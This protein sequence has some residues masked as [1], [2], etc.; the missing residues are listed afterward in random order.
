MSYPNDQGNP[1][2]SIPVQSSEMPASTLVDRSGTV[3]AG[4]SAVAVAAGG[5]GYAVNDTIS[6]GNGVSL[7][8]TTV[9]AG[10]ITAVSV[11]NIGSV[12]SAA[13]PTNPVAQV[14]T[15]GAGTGATFN[16]TWGA[17]VSTQI[18]PANA[19]RRRYRIQNLSTTEVLWLN[20]TGGVAG[21]STP[22]SYGLTPSQGNYPGDYYE[23]YSVF[24]ISVYA[25]TPGHV[26]SAAEY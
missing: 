13:T 12:A 21:A 1:A 19:A 4:V 15:S 24:A 8:V 5:T 2:S 10:V 11:A 18:M 3:N 23:F 16:L 26:F 7:L 14:A 6:I 17:G 20:D 25:A 9:N 22:G